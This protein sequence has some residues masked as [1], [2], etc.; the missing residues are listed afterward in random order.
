MPHSAPK[1]LQDIRKASEKIQRYSA[2]RSLVDYAA[3]DFLRSAVERQ[4]EIIGEA[5]LRLTKVDVSLTAQ[6]TDCRRII[7]FR[8][9]LVH[10][11]D[12]VNDQIVWD[13]VQ[14]HLPVLQHEVAALLTSL[15]MP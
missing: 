9:A 10:G 14:H 13:A 7:D 8:N 6:I 15:G 4:F 2:G 3:D 11:Y 12:A 1:L 5:L